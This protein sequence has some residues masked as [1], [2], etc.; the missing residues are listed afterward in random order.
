MNE[1]TQ[2]D[3]VGGVE[4]ANPVG[5]V[6]PEELVVAQTNLESAVDVGGHQEPNYPNELIEW[7]MVL[8][9]PVEG[10]QVCCT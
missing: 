1:M 6:W 9:H 5:V 10:I 7:P 2:T 3:L 4:E 8:D